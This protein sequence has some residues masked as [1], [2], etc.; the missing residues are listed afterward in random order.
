MQTPLAGR[1]RPQKIEEFVGQEHLLSK[2]SPIRRMLENKSVTSMILWGPPGV[3]KTTLA[4]LI[5]KYIHA[6][7]VAFSAVT[8][9]GVAAFKGSRQGKIIATDQ[10]LSNR[11]KQLEIL[12]YQLVS[13]HPQRATKLLKEIKRLMLPLVRQHC[14]V[15]QQN[16]TFSEYGTLKKLE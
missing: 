10:A 2:G 16:G 9:G 8:S 14:D 1:L 5:S 7:F 4:Y 3:G 11:I 15:E 13:N 12:L 6:N